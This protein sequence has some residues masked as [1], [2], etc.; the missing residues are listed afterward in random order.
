[1]TTGI[2]REQG[3]NQDSARAGSA[4][5]RPPQLLGGAYPEA[6][7]FTRVR[8]AVVEAAR[9]TTAEVA[10]AVKHGGDRRSEAIVSNRKLRLE[11]L[12]DRSAANGIG[13]RTQEKIDRL[14]RDFPDHHERVCRGELS[15]NAAA[16]EAGIVRPTTTVPLEPERAAAFRVNGKA[17]G[18]SSIPRHTSGTGKNSKPS[19]RATMI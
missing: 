13:K 17:N 9:A 4:S 19:R 8:A 10:G 14:A 2:P 5:V 16:L 1:M 3:I 11:T 15:V 7:E 12:P 18:I 6:K